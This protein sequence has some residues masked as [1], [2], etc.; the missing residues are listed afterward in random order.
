MPN[1]TK[2]FFNLQSE[3]TA[4]K[5][6]FYDLYITNYLFKI[7]MQF[8]ECL[9]ADLFCGC[10]QNGDAKGSPLILLDKIIYVL[11]DPIIKKKW[12]EPKIIIYFNDKESKNIDGL[13]VHLKKLHL[14]NNVELIT[15]CDN[16]GEAIRKII[17]N[18]A[19]QSKPKFFFLD[20]YSYSAISIEEIKKISALPKT[21][22]LLFIP[23]F[24]AYRF[25]SQKENM[26]QALKDFVSSYTDKGVVDYDDFMDFMGSIVARVKDVTNEF[27]RPFI[28]EDKSSKNCL[29]LITQHING[30]NLMNDLVWKMTGR[31]FG[32]S[33]KTMREIESEKNQLSMGFVV[34]HS[35]VTEVQKKLFSFMENNASATNI[36]LI[37]YSSVNY[38]PLKYA[39]QAM[40]TLIKEQKIEIRRLDHDNPKSIFINEKYSRR[41]SRAIFYLKK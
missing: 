10:G 12:K 23:V 38:F 22:I 15:T 39:N 6:K 30:L 25:C 16:Y 14:P 31:K 4:A 17:E 41:P 32:G 3:S 34:K 8:G 20:P 21:E 24:F 40:S 5:L 26:P 13:C 29:I 11:N 28:I 19:N 9:I 18:P 2:H 33:I 36:D 35:A 1:K 37:H 7:V 27:V